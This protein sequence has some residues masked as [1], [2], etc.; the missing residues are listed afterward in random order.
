L[1]NLQ[2]IVPA[3]WFNRCNLLRIVHDPLSSTYELV[4]ATST[5]ERFVTLLI[6][7]KRSIQNSLLTRIIAFIVGAIFAL[8]LSSLE[9]MYGIGSQLYAEFSV[10][11]FLAITLAYGSNFFS[12]VLNSWRRK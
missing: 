11:A 7:E 10:F 5:G 3:D 6:D 4:G 9:A 2:V 8:G 12:D 1:E